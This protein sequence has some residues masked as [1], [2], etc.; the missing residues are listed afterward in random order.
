[1][2]DQAYGGEAVQGFGPL[3]PGLLGYDPA[4][5]HYSFDPERCR[6]ELEQAWSGRVAANGFYFQLPFSSGDR[7]RQA[8]A[9]ILRQGIT[10]IDPRYRIETVELPRNAYNSAR[11]EGRLPILVSGWREDLHDPHNWAQPFL[12]GVYADYQNLPGGL[13]NLFA[14]PVSAGAAEVDP[15]ARSAIY[16]QLGELDYEYA[17]AI[18]GAVPTGRHYEQRWVRGW[19][20]N[21]IY[22]GDYYY[23][24]SED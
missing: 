2:I 20:F 18:R 14:D 12:V 8:V 23:A 16:A 21:P 5:A 17:I 22:P 11:D 6:S 24:L 19:Y 10:G 13:R 7:I 9:G 3:I 4:G 1:L 15:G